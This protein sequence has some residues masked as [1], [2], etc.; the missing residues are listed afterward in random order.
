MKK[1]NSTTTILLSVLL[2]L[3]GIGFV[4]LI[5]EIEYFWI[6]ETDPNRCD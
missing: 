1:L 3:S 6:L 4:Y 2:I 5:Y